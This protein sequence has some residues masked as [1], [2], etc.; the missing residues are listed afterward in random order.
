MIKSFNIY[1]IFWEEKQSSIRGTK[2]HLGYQFLCCS[3]VVIKTRQF[4]NHEPH[5]IPRSLGQWP[6]DYLWTHFCWGQ[7]CDFTQVSLCLSSMQIRQSMWRVT[8]NLNQKVSDPKW[9]LDD[10]WPYI[11]GGHLCNSTQVSLC[12][13]P[14][15]IYQLWIQWPFLYEKLK[16]LKG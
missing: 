5:L 16:N 13:P 7:V 2:F 1:C 10:L 14:M 8:K 9:S 15:D 12:P 4:L 11:G 6:L 3:T